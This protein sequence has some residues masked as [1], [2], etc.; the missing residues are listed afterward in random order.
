MTER[1]FRIL[2][3]LYT[4]FYYCV[5]FL[6]EKLYLSWY[7]TASLRCSC[8]EK[9]RLTSACSQQ[10]RPQKGHGPQYVSN[11]IR[12][13]THKLHSRFSAKKNDR[14]QNSD[15]NLTIT[16]HPIP[17]HFSLLSLY[18]TTWARKTNESTYRPFYRRSHVYQ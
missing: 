15:Q 18:Q 6:F 1:L 7:V 10:N 2:L 4:T 9:T 16:I 17:P 3:P 14:E 12:V 5:C 13:N 8:I 11:I